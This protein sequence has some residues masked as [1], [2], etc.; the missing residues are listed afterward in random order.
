MTQTLTR[1]R[2]LR[3]A[4][5]FGLSVAAGA[6]AAPYVA[7]GASSPIRIV[8]NPGLENA[9]LNALMDEMGYFRQYG[10][11]ASIAQIP[12]ATGPFDA[13]A[14]GA[15]DLCMVSGYNMV[16]A[17]IAQGA[18]VKIVGAGMKKCALT[19]FAKPDVV[20][21]LA[22]LEGKTVAVGPSLG[23]LHTLMLQ[24]MKEKGLDASQ[25]NFVDKG[26]NDQCYEAVVRGEAHACCSSIS[27]LRDHDGLV[28]INGANLWQ[29]LPRCTFQTA[30]AA[31]TALRDKHDGIVA[32]MAAYGALYEFLMSPASHDAFF[33]A[34]RHAQKNFDNASAQAI[35]DFNETQRPYSKD[36]SLTSDDIGYLQDMYISVGSLK[37]K[38]AFEEVADMSAAKAAAK[39][40]G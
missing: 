29:A 21:T 7:R 40:V 3:S 23:L 19:V 9:T 22:D 39:L 28:P 38:Q 18:K 4:G 6:L 25:V 35:W 34:R 10:V 30:Y 1:R 13:I 17:R 14:T 8:S 31:D 2:F 16:L 15:A 27:H 24:L 37:R 33:E 26:S 36:L 5:L 32:V 11:N 12:G 20:K